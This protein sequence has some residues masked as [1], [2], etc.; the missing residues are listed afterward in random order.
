VSR[1]IRTQPKAVSSGVTVSPSISRD[2][3]KRCVVLGITLDISRCIFNV[4]ILTYSF[5]WVLPN[6][7]VVRR[8]QA[9]VK[10]VQ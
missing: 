9:T 3:N 4:D 7:S 5:R 10:S 2:G 8:K 6:G 1:S